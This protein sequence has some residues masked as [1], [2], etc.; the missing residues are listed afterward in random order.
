VVLGVCLDSNTMY[1][2]DW[3]DGSNSDFVRSELMEKFKKTIV[4]P[5]IAYR[6]N[7]PVAYK[8]ARGGQ[9]YSDRCPYAEYQGKKMKIIRLV[10]G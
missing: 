3:D 5:L 1:Y 10:S 7:V 6:N 4:V 8:P 9:V 2:G